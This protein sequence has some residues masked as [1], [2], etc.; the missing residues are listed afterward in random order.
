VEHDLLQKIE[1]ER[2]EWQTWWANKLEKNDHL[3]TEIA[4]SG[5]KQS[6]LA[7]AAVAVIALHAFLA[8]TNKDEF[9]LIFTLY[10]SM[11][12]LC[13]SVA[14]QILLVEL[15]TNFGNEASGHLIRKRHSMRSMAAVA[16]FGARFFTRPAKLAFVF[17]YGSILWLV[18]YL[19]I[20]VTALVH[21]L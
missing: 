7:H 14:G 9:S 8:S 15:L 13:L 17:I 1:A 4:L 20:G 16:T 21:G 19:F 3:A 10:A 5:V 12:G 18:L 2:H 11:F 6:L